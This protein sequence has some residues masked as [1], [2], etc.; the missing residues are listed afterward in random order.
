MIA[1]F[2]SV[3]LGCAAMLLT[4]PRALAQHS[5]QETRSAPWSAEVL[6]LFATLPI[7][8]GGRIKPI[9]TF[10]GFKLL[11]M[12]GK[13]HYTTDAGERLSPVEWLL[14]CFFF[15]EQASEY[16]IFR[17][18]NEDVL[19][20]IDSRVPG[21]KKR[22]WYSYAELEPGL[23]R[24]LAKAHEF[25]RK[26]AKE[27]SLIETQ[28]VQLA[29]NVREFEELIHFLDFA[30]FEITVDGTPE[31]SALFDG[32]GTTSLS[33]VLEEAPGLVALFRGEIGDGDADVQ[34]ATELLRNIEALQRLG[35]GRLAIFPPEQ[36][37]GDNAEWIEPAE[38]ASDAFTD[39]GT[40]D[41]PLALLAALERMEA[42]KADP[43]A[44]LV[45]L[46]QLH[47]GAVASAEARGEYGKIPLEVSFYKRDYFTRALVFFL[48]AFLM[49]AFTWVKPSKWLHRGVWGAL[50]AAEVLLV[51]GITMR[52][53]IRGRPPV[54]T[55]YETILFI[56]AVAVLIAMVIEVINRQR[57]AIVVASVLGALG[58]FLSMKYE[59][60]EAVTA[61]DTMPS[62][63][64]VLDTNFWL[65]TH[66]TT[67]TMGYS[68][69]LLASAIA[70]VWLFGRMFG[71]RKGDR[72]FY[73][74][75]ARVVYGVLCFGLLFSV[76]GTILGGVWANYSWGRFWGW[77]P[78][79]NGALLICIWGIMTLHLRLGGYV[80]DFGFCIMAVLGGLV[81]SF[82]WWGVNLLGVGLHSYGFT[83]GIFMILFVMYMIELGVVLAAGAWRLFSVSGKAVG[84]RAV[85]VDARA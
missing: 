78:K 45:E 59:L 32:A 22:D 41:D 84:T 64:A 70:H 43:A 34:A 17:V 83:S 20:A 79:E 44:F 54:S 14:D 66:V 30:R 61:G 47:D 72:V 50:A 2:T 8:E 85:A 13:R 63:V 31:L 38:L 37:A 62:L 53:I 80:K 76:V 3:F 11:K 60:K 12:N 35:G 40:V 65:A 25:S 27:R 15:P 23:G 69:G 26:E 48:L 33:R 28:V 58:M 68:A 16:R 10:A 49:T 46:R 67:V 36:D 81:V 77:D 51:T 24:L 21:K 75:I 5:E 82:S 42:Q 52:C 7:Q 73:K 1:R 39:S 9:D 29:T 18:D 74:N 4:A 71:F 57:V 56:A 6:D 19:T 55:L